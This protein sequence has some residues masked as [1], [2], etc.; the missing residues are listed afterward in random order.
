MSKAYIDEGNNLK[1]EIQ[2]KAVDIESPQV[3]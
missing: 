1:S 2:D 3:F